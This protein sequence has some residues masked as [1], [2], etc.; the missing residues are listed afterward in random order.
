MQPGSHLGAV[1]PASLTGPAAHSHF[2]FLE[3]FARRSSRSPS[4][5]DLLPSRGALTEILIQSWEVMPFEAQRRFKAL[6]KVH[7]KMAVFTMTASSLLSSSDTQLKLKL[8]KDKE[9]GSI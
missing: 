9:A 1:A 5:R 7:L 4:L 6:V 3:P 2:C 8:S